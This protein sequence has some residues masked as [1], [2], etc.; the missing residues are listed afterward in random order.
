MHGPAAIGGAV[1][2]EALAGAAAA[3]A[4]ATCAVAT[5]ASGATAAV[6]A[7]FMLALNEGTT[8]VAAEF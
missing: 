3:A 4:E 7:A 1:A 5:E 2:A 6:G 8:F